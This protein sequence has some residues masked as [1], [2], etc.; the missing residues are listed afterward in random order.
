MRLWVLAIS[1]V[2]VLLWAHEKFKSSAESNPPLAQ[3]YA[4][5]ILAFF[6]IVSIAILVW[7]RCTDK[8]DLEIKMEGKTRIS[9]N[10]YAFGVSVLNKGRKDAHNC[11]VSVQV[12]DK[13][14]GKKIGPTSQS[15]SISQ[16]DLKSGE[17]KSFSL[18]GILAFNGNFVARISA[19]THK[20]KASKIV[21]YNIRNK[22]D[23]IIFKWGFVRH[24][25]FHLKRLF[26]KYRNEWDTEVLANGLTLKSFSDPMIRKELVKKLGEIGDNRALEPLIRCFE[27]DP[28]GT[29]CGRVA[30][31]LG[32]IGN[33]G[34]KRIIDPLLKCLREDK[35]EDKVDIKEITS[36]IEKMCDEE[37]VKM[38]I[39]ILHDSNKPLQTRRQIAKSLG[40]IG[41]KIEMQT[42]EKALIEALKDFHEDR[43][44][45]YDV[46][47]ALGK[48][49]S[50][51][52]E[53]ALKQLDENIK[54]NCSDRF[55]KAIA[56]IR[57]RISDGGNNIE[58]KY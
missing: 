44:E 58:E 27:N 55:K 41:T 52:S 46:V 43:D 35:R 33:I 23:P 49:G 20:S 57:Y 12:Y 31:A 6:N 8:P 21:E 45:L 42:I 53:K 30:V 51:N 24:F 11:R 40:E 3:A 14:S 37:C 47:E 2:V 39:D 26:K 38:L 54:H 7:D 36:A 19:E 18:Y 16:H 48:V 9:E 15:G 4:A 17:T 10:R 5:I 25:S 32:N 13:K 50:E 56:Q 34:D 22:Y 29:V 28:S 1:M